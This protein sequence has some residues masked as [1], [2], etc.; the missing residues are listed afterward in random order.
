MLSTSPRDVQSLLEHDK[1][2]ASSKEDTPFLNEFLRDLPFAICQRKKELSRGFKDPISELFRKLH[3]HQSDWIKY[4]HWD[5]SR[6]Y[7]RNLVATDHETYTLL[8]LCWNPGQASPIHDHPCD[9]CWMRVLQGCVHEER[10]VKS[11][12]DHR[13][14][15]CTRNEL[16]S[17]GE[18]LYMEDSMGY[19]RVGNPSAD[20]LAVTLH[21]YCP[22]Y[23]QCKIWADIEQSEPMIG[24]ISHYTEYGRKV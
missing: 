16:Y 24:Q 17:A 4:C 11:V 20:E 2:D 5:S 13:T 15:H 6:P 7:T 19:H 10:F 21:L 18:L 14:M 1:I 3:L 8:L 12:V 23:H 22:P 9:G